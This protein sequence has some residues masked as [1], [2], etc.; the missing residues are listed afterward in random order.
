MISENLKVKK[1]KFIK[2]LDKVGIENRPIVSG[3]FLNQ[4]A[5]KLYKLKSTGSFKNAQMVEKK[6]FFIGL[7]TKKLANDKANY[8]AEKLLDIDLFK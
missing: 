4:P 8:I 3:N 7:H 2:Y 6:G 5:S 1:E